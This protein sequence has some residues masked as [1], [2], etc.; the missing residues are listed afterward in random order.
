MA[1]MIILKLNI[2]AWEGL[3]DESAIS[4]ELKEGGLTILPKDLK[5]KQVSQYFRKRNG[6]ASRT[7]TCDKLIN[8]Q[9]LYQL[10]YCGIGRSR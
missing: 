8:S 2:F 5:P 9:L 1:S 7:R 10:S 6:S 4:D 3:A